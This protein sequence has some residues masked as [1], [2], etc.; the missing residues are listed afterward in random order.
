MRAGGDT[1]VKTWSWRAVTG[2]RTLLMVVESPPFP[3]GEKIKTMEV[4]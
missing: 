2:A 3:A 1:S 4:R